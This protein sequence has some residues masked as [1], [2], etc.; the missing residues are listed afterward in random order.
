LTPA[1]KPA[2]YSGLLGQAHVVLLPF[3]LAEVLADTGSGPRVFPSRTGRPVFETVAKVNRGEVR[4]FVANGLRLLLNERDLPYARLSYVPG[5]KDSIFCFRVDTDFGPTEE[6]EAVAGMAHKLSMRFTWFINTRAAES[7]LGRLT[8]TALKGQDIQL[9]CYRHRVYPDY[10]RNHEDMSRG[11]GLLRLAD[12]NPV[13]VAGP[14]GEWNETWSRAALDLG[15]EY[16]SEFGIGYDDVP[17]RPIVNGQRASLL[18]VP[19]H[20]ICLGRLSAARAQQDEMAGYFKTIVDT[21]A[22][23]LE[24]CLLYDHPTSLVR[25]ASQFEEVASYAKERC[26]GWVTMT[27]YARWWTEREKTDYRLGRKPDG[28]TVRTGTAAEDLRLVLEK[29]NM[30]AS[31]PLTATTVKYSE[32][33]WRTRPVPALCAGSPARPGLKVALQET[34]RR[35]RRREE[36]KR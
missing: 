29:D 25:F 27:D 17:F 20:P 22:V 1:R 15:L 35:R 28:L 18:Q 2:A 13:G 34:L 26:G 30:V 31:V 4:R 8:G 3:E 5:D 36:T 23:R 6:I 11:L 24:P 9:H 21:Q 7:E 16:S 32:L 19:V 33:E 12:V 10:E 14:Y